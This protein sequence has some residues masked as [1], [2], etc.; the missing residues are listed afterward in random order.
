MSERSERKRVLT[1]EA[2]TRL[3][4]RGFTYREISDQMGIT[5]AAVRSH[6]RA[7]LDEPP[8]RMRRQLAAN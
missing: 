2:A 5:V 3:Y 4:R 6:V 8:A 1:A 7:A